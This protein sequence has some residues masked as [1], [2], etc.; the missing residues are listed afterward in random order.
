MNRNCTEVDL[1]SDLTHLII[2]RPQ[3]YWLNW[4]WTC[5]WYI[6]LC[7][8]TW[9]I[10]WDL[11]WSPS[12]LIEVQQQVGSC[13]PFI[14]FLSFTRWTAGRQSCSLSLPGHTLLM[15]QII[16]NSLSLPCHLCQ[17]YEPFLWSILKNTC[18]QTDPYAQLTHTYVSWFLLLPFVM[19]R[20]IFDPL[21]NNVSLMC[22]HR[23]I[24]RS[25]AGIEVWP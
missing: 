24:T 20:R 8:T 23:F 3:V 7:I 16:K 11:L 15:I 9:H 6:E 12:F 25:L 4:S 2:T 21:I 13:S 5:K 10:A 14:F 1:Q 18:T 19:I 22:S 17:S